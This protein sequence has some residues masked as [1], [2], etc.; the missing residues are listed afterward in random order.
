MKDKKKRIGRTDDAITSDMLVEIMEESIRIFW[1]FV[2]ADKHETNV[3]L[4]YQKGTQVELQDPADSELLSEVRTN[5][6]KVRFPASH[7]CIAAILF[8][9]VL[10]LKCF[11]LV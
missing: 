7:I 10:S 6:Q 5:L 1:R 2:R 8:F 4:K 11:S 9:L 3:I